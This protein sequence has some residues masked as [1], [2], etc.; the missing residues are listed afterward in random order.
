VPSIKPRLKIAYAIQNVGGIDFSQDVGDTVPVKQSL[1]GLQRAGHEVRC[2]QLKNR[3][4]VQYEDLLDVQK[5]RQTP[6]RITGSAP[7]LKF[8][9]GIRRLQKILSL[10]YFAFFDTYR[11]YEACS[12]NFPAFDLCH[13]H[14]GLFC[15]GAAFACK[16]LRIPYI[17]TFSA[18]LLLERALVG[19]PLK[20][21]HARI[22]SAEA[23]FTYKLARKILCVS[24]A[25]KNHLIE[26]WQVAPEKIVIM[27]NGVDINLFTPRDAHRSNLWSELGLSG[28]QVITFVGG[29]QPW[30]GLE[31]LVESFSRLLSE[32]PNAKLLLVGDGRARQDVEKSI[33]K[34]GVASSIIITGMV[35]QVRIPEFLAIADLAVMP[36]P[37]LPKELWFS[38]LK[39]YEYMSAGKAIV[40]SRAGQIA[41]VI[42]DGYNGVL[43]E[44]GDIGNLTQTMIRL[45]QDEEE[46]KRLGSN[47]R[48]QAVEKH[49]WDQYVG[50]LES[51]YMDVLESTLVKNV[52]RL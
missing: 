51:I 49:S 42:E 39:M 4:V 47:A 21:L 5:T 18:D 50:R 35:P 2:F 45:L 33:Q 28:N 10:P 17:L 32:I 37:E 22:A 41:E 36:Y 23:R 30:H 44:P 7:F 46:R 52:Q 9:S 15:I 3:G 20:G 12:S 14:N 1:I 25:A 34:F 31:I 27:P 13:E 16:R 48:R 38:P 29:F 11:F 8:E 26:T 6:L 43:V 40:A 24:D 19:K